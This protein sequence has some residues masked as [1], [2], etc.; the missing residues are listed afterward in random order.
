MLCAFTIDPYQLN[1]YH[2]YLLTFYRVSLTS[3]PTVHLNGE[4][5]KMWVD[6]LENC[7]LESITDTRLNIH[8][9]FEQSVC[10]W[11]CRRSESAKHSR[12]YTYSTVVAASA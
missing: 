11:L 1:T 10:R 6:G 4:K 2:A 3:S 5:T 9:S 8:R 12:C 7:F